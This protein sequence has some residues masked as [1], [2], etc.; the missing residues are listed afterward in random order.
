MSFKCPNCGEFME[1]NDV[2]CGNCGAKIDAPASPVVEDDE[3]TFAVDFGVHPGAPVEEDDERT[4]AADYGTPEPTP[5]EPEPMQY[6][7][8][9]APLDEQRDSGVFSEP[10]RSAFDYGDREYD[11]MDTTPPPLPEKKKKSKVGLIIAIIA[12]VAVIGAAVAVVLIFDPFGW[13]N[14]QPAPQGSP[15]ATQAPTGEQGGLSDS[16]DGFDTP[17]AAADAFM[18][19]FFV[20]KNSSKAFDATYEVKLL[21]SDPEEMESVEQIGEILDVITSLGIEAE[22]TVTKEVILS[23]SEEEAVKSGLE[24]QSI[25]TDGITEYAL[26]T[27]DLKMTV[28]GSEDSDTINIYC[29][30][31]DGRWYVLLSQME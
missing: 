5:S 16:A 12:I 17:S 15:L 20:E 1:D 2:F 3:R 25:P 28:F 7:S 24:S 4:F 11:A 19:A 23:G 30:K 6:S 29:A 31:Y 9:F 10:Q 8:A 18:N 14:R 27:V 26:V 21:Q 22:C 13:F